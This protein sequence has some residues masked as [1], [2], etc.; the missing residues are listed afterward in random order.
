MIVAGLSCR[1]FCVSVMNGRHIIV[2]GLIIATAV[3]SEDAVARV[4]S[5]Q[6]ELPDDALL[7]DLSQSLAPSDLAK[8]EMFCL[9]A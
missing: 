2:V 6:H 3:S 4:D 9:L 1:C 5:R 7:G 8:L